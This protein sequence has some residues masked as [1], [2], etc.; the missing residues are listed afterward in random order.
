MRFLWRPSHTTGTGYIQAA[1]I[2]GPP[3]E[4][5]TLE[6][7][8]KHLQWRAE[9]VPLAHEQVEPFSRER[10]EVETR[11]K[12][13]RACGNPVVPMTGA[14]R[15]RNIWA[16]W[17]FRGDQAITHVQTV[18]FEQRFQELLRPSSGRP[19]DK[20]CLFQSCIQQRTDVQ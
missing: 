16:G 14:D 8:E 10:N 12:S 18:A 6:Q 3:G 1:K 19:D 9:G 4:R 17:R 20:P 13:N 2:P 7:S 11:G 5:A 15:L